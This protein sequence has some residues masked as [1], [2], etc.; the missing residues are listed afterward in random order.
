MRRYD[1]L[2]P[3][4]DHLLSVRLLTGLVGVGI[5]FWTLGCGRRLSQSALDVRIHWLLLAGLGSNPLADDGRSLPGQ[6]PLFCVLPG[7]G[8]QLDL[9]FHHHRD[10]ELFAIRTGLQRCLRALCSVARPWRP[11][12]APGVPSK[13]YSAGHGLCP[14][15]G[16]RNQRALL[17]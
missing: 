12:C 1:A 5:I 9:L 7:S 14:E 16:S 13:V 2:L 4:L 10:G 8:F 3:R 6:D 15:G 11:R 17:R